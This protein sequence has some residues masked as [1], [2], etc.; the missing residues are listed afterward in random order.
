MRGLVTDRTQ[1]NVIRLKELTAKGWSEMT[2]EEQ[3]EWLG[4]P[5]SGAAVNLLPYA[6][7]YSSTVTLKRTNDAL[8]AETSSAGSYLYAV[9]IVG[10]AADFVEKTMTLSADYIGTSNGGNPQLA[11]YWHDGNG[12]EFA[13]GALSEAGSVTFNTGANT[14]GR[15]YLAM[16]VYVTGET[17]VEAGA[18]VRYRGVM[19]EFGSMRHE[20]V[21]YMEVIPTKATKGAYNYSDLN[22]VERTVEELSVLYGLNLETK[23]DWDLWDIPTKA[24]MVRYI[25]NIKRIRQAT[26]RPNDIA[27]APDGM[28]GLNFSD[29]NNIERILIAAHE[30]T[31]RVYRV[32]EL[33]CG[34]VN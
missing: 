29:A 13:G 14:G 24:E 26:L 19:L 27:A 30:N 12:F 3:S 8:I 23:T 5:L 7:F 18:A 25:T 4:S 16:Y 15:E 11:M 2:A 17:A 1:E 22:R 34:E 20:Y 10:E 6:P 21:P 32:G 9:L 33:F 31:D 28:N